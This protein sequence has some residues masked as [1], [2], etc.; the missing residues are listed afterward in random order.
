MEE[1]VYGHGEALIEPGN[2]VV[3]PAFETVPM[4]T[5]TDEDAVLKQFIEF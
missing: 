3:C 2:I 1:A 4:P 5:A